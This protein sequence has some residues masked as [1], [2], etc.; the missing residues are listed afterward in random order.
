MT[1]TL[2]SRT[3][4]PC[5]PTGP[6]RPRRPRN[7]SMQLTAPESWRSRKVFR[8]HTRVM[9]HSKTYQE[10]CRTWLAHLLPVRQDE[11]IRHLLQPAEILYRSTIPTMTWALSRDESDS[12]RGSLKVVWLL[13]SSIINNSPTRSHHLDRRLNLFDRGESMQCCS[14]FC[15]VLFCSILIDGQCL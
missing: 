15:S 13:S 9:M 6:P 8:T 10:P 2:P 14:L 5:P 4:N 1:S 3:S 12:A 11:Q 7:G